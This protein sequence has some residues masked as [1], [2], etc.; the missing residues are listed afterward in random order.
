MNP[1][2][3]LGF[4]SDPLVLNGRKFYS[5]RAVASFLSLNPSATQLCRNLCQSDFIYTKREG[6]KKPPQIFVSEKGFYKLLL[7]HSNRHQVETLIDW[8]AGSVLPSIAETGSY[9]P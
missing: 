2:K 3:D 8:I 4:N 9:N 5:A 1:S 6:S 7:Q